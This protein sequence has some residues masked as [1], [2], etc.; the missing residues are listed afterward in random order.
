MKIAE[1]SVALASSST[2]SSQSEVRESLRITVNN[3]RSD[4]EN[5]SRPASLGE[6]MLQVVSLPEASQVGMVHQIDLVA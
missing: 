3:G 5:V 1:S 6:E 4:A 2:F